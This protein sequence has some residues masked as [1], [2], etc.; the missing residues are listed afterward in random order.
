MSA[1]RMREAVEVLK[2]LAKIAAQAPARPSLNNVRPF[3]LGM[4]L[5]L[6]PRRRCATLTA[7]TRSGARN[8]SGISLTK[9]GYRSD[10]S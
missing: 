9:R 1:G 5:V 4:R 3:E 6:I 8:A 10:S 2:R 7:R